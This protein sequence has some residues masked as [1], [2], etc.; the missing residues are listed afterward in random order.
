MTDHADALKH[1]RGSPVVGGLVAK[2]REI[3]ARLDEAEAEARRLRDELDQLDGVIRMFRP[4]MP[5]DDV[6]PARRHT[7]IPE[8]RRGELGRRVLEQLRHRIEPVTARAVTDAVVAD[9]N[10]DPPWTQREQLQKN[11]TK[12]LRRYQRY[13][14]VAAVGHDRRGAM[15]WR[16]ADDGET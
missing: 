8:F 2:R 6:K 7:R 5:V 15:L 3:A 11:V 10:I 14:M 4:E 12:T 1:I 13:G 9:K 16:L